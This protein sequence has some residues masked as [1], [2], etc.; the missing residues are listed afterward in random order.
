MLLFSK[1]FHAFTQIVEVLSIHLWCYTGEP[2]EIEICNVKEIFESPSDRRLPLDSHC[3]SELK[4][5][6]FLSRVSRRNTFA[7]WV[8]L[9]F[10]TVKIIWDISLN[11]CF[12]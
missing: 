5:W 11:Q 9:V 7:H 2:Y 4:C 10:L 6:H 1:L 8:I 3:L 12:M